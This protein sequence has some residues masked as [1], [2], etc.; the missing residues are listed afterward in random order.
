MRRRWQHRGVGSAFTLS[1]PTA[2]ADGVRADPHPIGSA[3]G[4]SQSNADEA[5]SRILIEPAYRWA[6]SSS[7]TD[8]DALGDEE[9]LAVTDPRGDHHHRDPDSHGSAESVDCHSVG[10]YQRIADYKPV[11]VLVSGGRAC[12]SRSKFLVVVGASGPIAC[13]RGSDAP[14]LA[15]TP[16]TRLEG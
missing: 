9:S 6:D 8:I 12:R 3:P 11:G 15:G 7:R 5:E 1:K 10:D 13:R 2:N 14:S 4:D 16:S